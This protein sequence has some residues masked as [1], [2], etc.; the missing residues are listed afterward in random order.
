V[1]GVE[2]AAGR[3]LALALAEAGAD[4]ATVAGRDDA[5]SAFAAKR[6]SAQIAK[7]GR[8]SQAQAID[9]TL[10]TAVQVVTRQ[11]TKEFGGLDIL[12]ACPDY[13][14]AGP[15]GRLSDAQWAK[16]VG[17][18]L[19]A[20]FFACRS[21]A[22]EMARRGGGAIVVVAAAGDGAAYNALKAAAVQLALG[23]AQEYQGQGIR[24][25]A[26]VYAG[27]EPPGLAEQALAL[28]AGEATGQVLRLG[29]GVKP[30]G[31]QIEREGKREP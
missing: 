15:S 31:F 28:L 16:L 2:T 8:R 18:N 11:V 7:R 1:L 22:R 27:G 25:N 21:A 26:I 3:A 13:P 10:A 14:Q 6:L 23:L 30:V 12:V 17:G 9:A 4:V 24:L 19:S 20:I 5:E 29:G